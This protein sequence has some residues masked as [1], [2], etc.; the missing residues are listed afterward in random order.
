MNDVERL[1]LD[2]SAYSHFRSGNP[3]VLERIVRADRVVVPV[4]VAGELEAAFANGRR[5][6]DNRRMLEEFLA[7]P[8][9]RLLDVTAKTAR[10]YGEVFTK[11]RRAGTPIPINDVWIA[12]S[13]IECH[14]HLL[15]FDSDFTRV[16]G[17]DHTL[18]AAVH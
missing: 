6:E 14:G 15:T 8:F 10:V 12:A 11:L 3:D 13:T 2:T 17:M 7:E 5:A 16:A 18:L 4:V 1:V 9:V